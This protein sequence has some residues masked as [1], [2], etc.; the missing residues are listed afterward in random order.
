M[1]TMATSLGV[2]V[3]GLL[4]AVPV[5][6]AQD[7]SAQLATIETLDQA[8]GSAI[9]RHPSVPRAVARVSEE[10]ERVG[11]ARSG[12]LPQLRGGLD[13]GHGWEGDQY[14]RY[15]SLTVS[16]LLYDFGRTSNDV[17]L[18][19]SG[20]EIQR[21][22]LALQV[23]EL[24]DEVAQAF[25]EVLR[26]EELL[27]LVREHIEKIAG[28]GELARQRRSLGAG[29]GSDEI[30]ARSREEA[31][32]AEELA[33]QTIQGRWRVILASLVQRPV[34]GNLDGIDSIERYVCSSS[35]VEDARSTAVL[36][37]EAERVE[38]M[39]QLRG[40]RLNR[41]PSVSLESGLRKPV[42]DDRFADGA[43]DYN[44]SLRVS[45]DL[46]QGGKLSARSRSAEHRL[47]SSQLSV[48]LERLKVAQEI[49][50]ASAQIESLVLREQILD[51]QQK[52][53]LETVDLYREQYVSLGNRSLLDLLNAERELHT[54]RY[55]KQ[56]VRYEKAMRKLECM[57]AR[58]DLLESFGIDL[59]KL[60]TTGDYR[61]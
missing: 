28:I 37:A 24:T 49:D 44:I 7:P 55:E 43:S 53:A 10:T 4:L 30:Q 61:L 2:L 3:A 56:N 38:A 22:R 46:Y 26:Y 5:I 14:R 6:H 50:E 41:Y 32:R 51:A 25:T 54:A 34:A 48:D 36:L 57:S 27:V 47:R 23:E 8:V 60:G 29:N 58:G 12:Y 18:A 52:S 31:A 33:L 17:E 59:D 21:V 1:R 9:A 42:L 20:V 35:A 16:Q 39:S 19:E 15:A 40:Q 11:E 45:V 13:M